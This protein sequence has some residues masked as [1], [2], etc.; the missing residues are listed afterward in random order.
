M[1]AIHS[2]VTL[3][4]IRGEWTPVQYAYNRFGIAQVNQTWPGSE[5][6]EEA[7]RSAKRWAKQINAPYQDPK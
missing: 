3:E 6:A 1:A 4:H 7:A 2:S 5:D